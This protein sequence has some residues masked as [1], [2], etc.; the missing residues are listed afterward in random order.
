MSN[1]QVHDS[2]KAL[3]GIEMGRVGWQEVQFHATLRTFKPWL[4][5]L[6]MMVTCIVEYDVNHT[7]RGV[8]I[9]NLFQHLPGGYS[10]DLF[11]LNKDELKSFEIK[12]AL[13]VDPLATRCGFNRRLLILREPT[14]SRTALIL[15]GAKRPQSGL[16]HCYPM[17]LAMPRTSL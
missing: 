11:A 17:T 14:M 15:G 12:C 16:S 6:G 13:N 2:P 1:P 7:H 5:Y 10:I 8:G 3:N 9:R 4:K